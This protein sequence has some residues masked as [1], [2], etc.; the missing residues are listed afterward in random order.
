MT[1]ARRTRGRSFANVLLAYVVALAVSIGVGFALGDR[2]E[3]WVGFA[4][5]I[6]ATLVV[7]AFSVRFDNSSVYDAYWSVAPPALAVYWMLHPSAEHGNGPRQAVVL[8]LVCIWGARL[9]WNWARGWP[10]MHHEDWRYVDYRRK[11][12]RLYWLVSLTGI[13]GFP[14]LLVFAG[15]LSVWV[16]MTSASRFGPVDIAAIFVTAGAIAIEAISDEQLRR[17]RAS[18]PTKGAIMDRGLWSWSRHPNYF[19]ELSFWWGLWLF[20][21]AAEPGI[22]WTIVGPAA[23]TF[24]FFVISVPLLDERSVARRPAYADHMKRVSAIV[25][26]PPRRDRG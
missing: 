13:H 3:L 15:C 8:A 18:N 20:A 23:M 11:T 24:L 26:L 6:A 16:S 9:T 4:A 10:G 1:E 19:G 5:D 7:F 22:W 2:S 17:F 25:P 21:I 12:G 14:T